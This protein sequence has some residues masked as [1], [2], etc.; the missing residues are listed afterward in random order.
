M[1]ST[2]KVKARGNKSRAAARKKTNPGSSNFRD[3]AYKE[4]SI[5]APRY[6]NRVLTDAVAENNE[7][8]TERKS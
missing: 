2:H 7:P 3:L 1:L 5:T 6:A 4:F 8:E